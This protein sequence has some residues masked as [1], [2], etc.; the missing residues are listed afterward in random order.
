MPAPIPAFVFAENSLA[1]ANDVALRD[2]AVQTLARSAAQPRK[3]SVAVA[4]ATDHRIARSEVEV[5]LPAR[6]NALKDMAE[7]FFSEM[8]FDF[9]YEEARQLFSIGFRVEDSALDPNCYDLLASEARLASFIAIAREDVPPKH[10]FR[11]GRTLTPVGHGSALISWS[12]SMFEYLMP[13]LVMRAPAGSILDLT[14]RLAVRGQIEYGRELGVPW[15]ISESLFY[16]RDMDGTYQYAGFGVPDLGYKRG[17]GENIVIA[18]YATA[19]AAM[20]EPAAAAEN[21]QRLTEEGGRGPYGW[22]EALDYTPSR[23]PEGAKVAIVR[24]YMAHHHAMSIVAIADALL[25]GEMRER[26][27]ADA[28]IKATELLLQERMPRDIPIA[29]PPALKVRSAAVT[30]HVAPEMKRRFN[31]PHS[32]IPRTHLLSNGSYAV[33]VTGAGSG[34]SRWRN[35]DVTRWREDVT[36]DDWGSYIFLRDCRSGE[37]WSAGYQPTG[38]EPDHYEA[39]FFEDHAEFVRHDGS[40]RTTLEISVSPEHDAEVRRVSITNLGTRTREIELTSYAELVLGPYGEDATH[41]AFSKLFVETEFVPDAGTL[42]ATRRRRSPEQ[43][44]IWAAHLMVIEGESSGNMQFETDRASFMGRGQSIRAPQCVA[45]GWPLSN[46]VGCVLDP[47]FSLRCRLRIPRGETMRVSFWTMIA[48]SRQ[49]ALDLADKHRDPAGF[50]RVTTMA[51]TQAQGQFHHLGIGP[52]E[53]HLFQRLAN[54][55]I[56]SGPDVEAFVRSPEARRAPC[57]RA[58]GARHL[59]R[60]ADRAVADRPAR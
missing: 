31:S 45:D 5:N 38:V 40:L 57:F 36:C 19:L 14:T 59:R 32:R 11:L 26:F 4:P 39:S 52:A 50:D 10:W 41:P 43:P 21:F 9:L 46:T 20:V 60:P 47:I 12:G 7:S 18:P 1:A 3:D 49:E 53:A 37:T 34:Y 35:L 29:R 54:R 13:S 51:W 22:Y 48:G 2:A 42:L 23:L 30:E 15:G 6:L 58:M 25:E 27:H 56:Y 8:K 17:L 44:E 55:V 16:A 28:I 33:M 24:A